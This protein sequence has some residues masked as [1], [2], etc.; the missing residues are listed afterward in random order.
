MCEHWTL[1]ADD[2]IGT[3]MRSDLEQP[4]RLDQDDL[5]KARLPNPIG[6]AGASLILTNLRRPWCIDAA[7]MGPRGELWHG[8]RCPC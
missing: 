4:L 6:F 5:A 3:T 1:V 8:P 7:Q 2:G